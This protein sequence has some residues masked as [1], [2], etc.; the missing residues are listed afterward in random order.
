MTELIA[1]D[2]IANGWMFA[3]GAALLTVLATSWTHLKNVYAQI[4]SRIVVTVTVSGYQSEALL[5]FLKS[6]LQASRWGP[7]AYLGWMLYVRPAR[8]VQLVPMEVAPQAGKLYWL[9]WRPLWSYKSK[10]A[11]DNIDSGSNSR[12]W[13]EECL[14]LVFLRGTFDADQLVVMATDWFNRQVVANEEA[15]GRRHF[16]RHIYGTAGKSTAALMGTDGM[17][18]KAGAPSSSTDIRGCLQYRPLQWS[19]SDLGPERDEDVSPLDRLA[20]SSEAEILVEEAR[21]WKESEAWYKSRGI[22]WRRGWLL[23]GRPGT[24]KTAL[25]RAVAEELDLPVFVYDLASLHNHEL[26]QEWANM[27]AEVP[28]LALIE[29][30]DAVFDG[31]TNTSAGH[32]RQALTFDCVLNCLDGIERADGLFVVITTNRLEKVDP[33]LGRPDDHTGSTRPGRV[34]HILEMKELDE[35]G[36]RKMASRILQEWPGQWQLVIEAGAGDTPA[37][38]QERCARRALELHYD[39]EVPLRLGGTASEGSPRPAGASSR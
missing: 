31:R 13:T 22:P 38:F 36:R 7:R 4:A 6:H 33:A 39:D 17:R 30:I 12:E 1:T 10:G 16:I 29:D 3:G 19:F 27:L 2:L 34:D 23:H 28:C 32:D 11:P 37:Q 24:G 9:G 5:L 35:T 20:L 15:G 14:H 18:R 8:R 25:A 26:Q 21:R